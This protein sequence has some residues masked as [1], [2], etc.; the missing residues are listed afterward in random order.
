MQGPFDAELAAGTVTAIERAREGGL[1]DPD[2]FLVIKFPT[3][4]V[5]AFL[6]RVYNEYRELSK[7]ATDVLT[8]LAARFL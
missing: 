5:P 8:V 1:I 2:T 4:F 3:A 7:Q 6:I